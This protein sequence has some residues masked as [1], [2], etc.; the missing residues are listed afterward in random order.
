MAE[1]HPGIQVLPPSAGYGIVIGIGGVFALIMLGI[2]WTQN[3]YT[4]F[5]THQAEE[6]NTASRSVKPGLIASGI[7]SSWTWSAT[8]LT[9]STFAYSY[10][11]CGGMW[12]AAMGTLQILLFALIAI[13]IKANAPGA[14]TFPEI[15]LAKHGH[16]AHVSYLFFGLATNMLVGACLVLGGSQVVA[17]LSGMNVY[18][19]CFLIPLVVAA[20]VITGGLRSTF[21][22]DYIHTAILFIVIFVF[23]FLTY[24]TSDLIGSPSRFYDMLV[25]A[26]DDMP[27]AKNAGNGSYLTFRSVDGLAFAIDIFAAG[28]STCWLDQA[29]WQR[30]IASRPETSVKAYILGGIAW[31]G[32]P[33]GFATAM[34]LGCAALTGDP[35]FPTYPNPL[36]PEQNS[37]GLSSPATAIALLGQGGAVLMLVLLFMAVT[38]STSAELIAV[39]SLL[40]FDVY[41][42]YI[43]PDAPST[44]LVQISHYGIMIYALVLAAFCCVL[45]AVG[46]N[47]TWLLTVLAI[48]VGGAAIP[49]GLVLLWSRMSIAAAICAPWVGLVCGL[50]A[51]FLTSWKRSGEITVASTGDTTNAVAGNVTSFGVGWLVAVVLSL[52]FPAKYTSMDVK[53]IERANKIQG[54]SSHQAVSFVS[55]GM[56]S[57]RDLAVGGEKEDKQ[58][59]EPRSLTEPTPFANDDLGSPPETSNIEPM[60]ARAVKKGTLIAL[61]ANIAF[62]LIA[63]ILVPFTLF[64]TG[65][66]YSR[67][68]FTGWV[69]V[70]FLWV[71][72]SM[73]ICVIYPIVESTGALR[74]VGAG[75]WADIKRLVGNDRDKGKRQETDRP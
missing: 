45:N 20:Y 37:A 11:V 66:V 18:A 54:I 70:S 27:I 59:C 50:L 44:K 3:R 24:A 21:I 31:Y 41:K 1:H 56:P 7:V 36:T 15:V 14:H 40:T 4:R 33:F 64:G 10:G 8:L 48:I 65:Y 74:E 71:W 46:L 35:R 68:F 73:V 60:D 53:H 75:M 9:S 51:W 43:K 12:Y 52:V 29:Y 28:F 13:K 26:S 34:G 72:V 57:S 23:G 2:T 22:A 63:V 62:I 67:T 6:F 17:A 55:E 32:I 49:I 58:P 19:A 61:I 5:S 25:E 38:S 16:I 47:L 39:S 30:A 42:T 69:V